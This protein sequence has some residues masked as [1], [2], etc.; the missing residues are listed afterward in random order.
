MRSMEKMISAEL[1]FS[2]IDSKD[3]VSDIECVLK[4]IED[5]GLEYIIGVMS[6]TVIGSKNK[7]MELIDTIYEH[8]NEQ[9]GFSFHI[10]ISN[11]CLSCAA[12]KE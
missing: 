7:I 3:Y 11:L 5:S 8:M 2:P 1:S 4:D 6:T 10:N 9:C 12:D